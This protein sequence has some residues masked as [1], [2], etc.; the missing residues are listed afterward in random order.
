MK[1]AFF[2]LFWSCLFSFFFLICFYY[3][4]SLLPLFSLKVLLLISFFFFLNSLLWVRCNEIGQTLQLHRFFFLCIS[5]HQELILIIRLYLKKKKEH[6]L[7]DVAV[8]FFF[9]PFFYAL[10]VLVSVYMFEHKSPWTC[11]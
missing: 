8:F 5:L 1:D 2:S 11:L 9:F 3:L 4:S 10:R 6:S 7:L